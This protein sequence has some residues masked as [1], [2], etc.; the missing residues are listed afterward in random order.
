[1]ARP[2]APP[3]PQP[4]GPPRVRPV[5]LPGAVGALLLGCLS[6]TPS[7]LPRGG[8]LQGVVTGI[9]A[10]I[11]YGLGVTAAWIWRALADRGPRPARRRSW[12][13]LLAGGGVLFCNA[14]G[15]GQYWQ[16]R[17]R[18]LLGVTDHSVPHTVL[19]P[20]VAFL[21]FALLL[22]AARGIR[23]VHRWVAR[24]LRRWIGARAAKAVGGILG[25][26]EPRVV[27]RGDRVQRRV[28]PPEPHG[29]HAVRRPAPLQHA[30]PALQ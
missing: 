2:E 28:R 20:F 23:R 26:R 6:F 24:Q 9:L 4:H 12:Q 15:L 21:L 30:L 8:I 10:A 29:R 3:T 25:R 16:H 1:M 13:L 14:F 17:I 7:L 19:M 18:A 11:G 27:R 5:T 22:L